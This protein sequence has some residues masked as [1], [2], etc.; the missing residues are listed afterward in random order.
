MNISEKNKLFTKEIE[1]IGIKNKI[2]LIYLNNLTDD[3]CDFFPLLTN[4]ENLVKILKIKKK[5]FF[6]ILKDGICLR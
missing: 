2:K 3:F 5:K 4:N 1:Q 6:F